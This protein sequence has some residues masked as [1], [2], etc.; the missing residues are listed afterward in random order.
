VINTENYTRNIF[1]AEKKKA[2]YTS[3][4]YYLCDMNHLIKLHF[5]MWRWIFLKTHKEVNKIMILGCNHAATSGSAAAAV[6]VESD[7]DSPPIRSLINAKTPSGFSWSS[8]NKSSRLNVTVSVS[9]S[10][11]ASASP[12]ASAWAGS[13]S[14]WRANELKARRANSTKIKNFI[15]KD[16]NYQLRVD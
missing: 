8:S 16:Y 12:A 13:Y 15:S 9:V 11:S 5:S 10:V 7:S 1:L 6:S 14:R 3:N 4:K 2:S